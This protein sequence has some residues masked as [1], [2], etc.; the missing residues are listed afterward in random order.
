MEFHFLVRVSC[1]SLFVFYFFITFD[2]RSLFLSLFRILLMPLTSLISL[3]SAKCLGR[4]I[5]V[6]HIILILARSY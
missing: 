2:I 3:A 6:F 4:P 5:V 1:A